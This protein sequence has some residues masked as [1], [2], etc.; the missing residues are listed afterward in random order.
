[1]TSTQLQQ[2][3]DITKVVTQGFSAVHVTRG[4]MAGFLGNAVQ[5]QIRK[6]TTILRSKNLLSTDVS[7]LSLS[8]TR[9]PIMGGRSRTGYNLPRNN[10]PINNAL[11]EQE[12]ELGNNH[13]NK[14]SNSSLLHI[15]AL[16]TGIWLV[17][18]SKTK[19][20]SAP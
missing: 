11:S 16:D 19:K 4:K 12:H 5:P 1:V 8:T 7:A 6:K 20:N 9:R 18:W 2:R 17:D 15:Y 13:K 14:N 10:Q 3:L